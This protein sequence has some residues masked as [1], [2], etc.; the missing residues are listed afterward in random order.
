MGPDLAESCKKVV[1]K[2]TAIYTMNLNGE[3]TSDRH[4]CLMLQLYKLCLSKNSTMC[5]ED[6]AYATLTTVVSR[7]LNGLCLENSDSS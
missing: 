4:V 7:L 1:E 6:S 5:A 2:C 3:T